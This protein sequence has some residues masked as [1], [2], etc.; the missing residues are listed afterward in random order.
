ML[1]EHV[2]LK[3]VKGVRGA[4]GVPKRTMFYRRL[5]PQMGHHHLLLLKVN[6]E[7]NTNNTSNTTNT[8]NNTTNNNS[9][10]KVDNATQPHPPAVPPSAALAR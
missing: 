3:G 4:M 9:N 7:V 8:T 2:V 1:V 6:N 5:H 10:D